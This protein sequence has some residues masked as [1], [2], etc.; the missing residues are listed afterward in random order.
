[1]K[2]KWIYFLRAFFGFSQRE[3]RGFLLVVPVLV[4]LAVIPEIYRIRQNAASRE[5]YQ[6]YL[7][8]AD[9]ILRTN[10]TTNRQQ[11]TAFSP[12]PHIP[13]PA[14]DTGRWEAYGK[15]PQLNKVDFAEADSIL[16]QI[17]PGIGATLAARIVKFRDGL[18]G[19]TEKQQLMEVYGL[20][21]EVAKR[22]FDYFDFSP[23]EIKKLSVNEADVKQL[24]A[25]PYIGYG[26]AK[27]IV[28]YRA[29]HG[30]YQSAEDLLK[31]KILSADW[32]DRVAPY[33]S[34]D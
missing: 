6:D 25:H 9:S 11:E 20:K 28:A 15:R 18:G 3:S 5:A 30:K 23:S 2:K 26:E 29:Q 33:L 12:P 34:F 19:L 14:K 22:I 4:V 31:I 7:L 10:K 24:A 17:V 8:Q 21:E 13:L 32:V 1:M 27:V 16:L